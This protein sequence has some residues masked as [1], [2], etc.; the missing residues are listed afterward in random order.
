MA[1]ACAID[2]LLYDWLMAHRD[3][4]DSGAVEIRGPQTDAA[5]IVHAASA[6]VVCRARLDPQ[7]L[8]L[9]S[10]VM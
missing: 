5:M 9:P 10:P 3:G 6:S 1:A 2:W 4:P 8:R 7:L